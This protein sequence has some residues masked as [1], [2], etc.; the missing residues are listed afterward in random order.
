[1]TPE[2]IDAKLREGK[3]LKGKW[4]EETH[5]KKHQKMFNNL[6]E[7]LADLENSNTA[8]DLPK[9]R[10]SIDW[11][12]ISVSFLIH[13][14]LSNVSKITHTHEVK[15]VQSSGDTKTPETAL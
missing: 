1:M 6:I 11:D 3:I 13:W 12:T 2:D 8:N 10:E 4:P 9:N 5:E 7:L 14:A 15:D